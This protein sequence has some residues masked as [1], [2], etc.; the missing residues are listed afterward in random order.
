MPLPGTSRN[1]PLIPQI[2]ADPPA[3]R[4][5][6]R[7]LTPEEFR[8]FW[9]WLDAR[10]Q[11][12]VTAP[13]L[14]MIMATG[15]R[16]TEI[17]CVSIQMYDGNEKII[18]W[19]KTKNGMP[20]A[21]PLPS[22]AVTVLERMVP[23]RAGLFFPSRV[24]R[25]SPPTMNAVEKMVESYIEYSGVP[26]FCPRDLR[27]TWKTLAGAAGLSKDIRDRIQNHALKDISSRHYDR[28]EYLAEKRAAKAQWSTYL[29]K[30][31]AGG[32]VVS[33]SPLAADGGR[34]AQ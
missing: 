6:E 9:K 8:D 33:F 12:S 27:R 14:Q 22:Q 21:I 26:D 32:V 2:P 18:D 25:E 17:L 3:N 7:H 5:G 19:S 24:N 15:Q 30:L 34:I 4:V 11:A 31:L 20:H 10:R 16:V 29:N 1:F 23:S 13:A 28:Y